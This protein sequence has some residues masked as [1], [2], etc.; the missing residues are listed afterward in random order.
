MT[1][2]KHRAVHFGRLA[3]T[4]CALR[5]MLSGHTIIARDY[6][7]KVGEI[8]IIARR[9]RTLVIVEVKGRDTLFAATLA[10]QPTQRRRIERAAADFI[11]RH[12]QY[13]AF[14]FRFDVM[15]V[16]RW[17]WPRHLPG[18]WMIGD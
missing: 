13:E 15:A 1:D 8:D 2:G 18:A 16:A 14:D 17:R 7:T 3:E 5:L 4:L 9:G 10:L 11:A 12:P 6:R